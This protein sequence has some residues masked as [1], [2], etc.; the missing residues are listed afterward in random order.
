ME[1]QKAANIA[2]EITDWCASGQGACSG[3]E[4]WKKQIE[5]VLNPLNP[6]DRREV[7]D[8]LKSHMEASEGWTL[9]DI[10]CL[11]RLC[12]VKHVSFEIEVN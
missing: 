1:L 8:V 2:D 9:E 10:K 3:A 12:G 6:V 7:W 5:E 11:A 4:F